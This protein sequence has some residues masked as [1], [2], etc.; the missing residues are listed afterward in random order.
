MAFERE[1]AY[2]VYN[3]L[4]QSLKRQ[5]Q[6][7]LERTLKIGLVGRMNLEGV[8]I[9]STKLDHH[10]L[11]ICRHELESIVKSLKNNGEL[12]DNQFIKIGILHTRNYLKILRKLCN[13]VSRIQN[14]HSLP[15]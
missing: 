5:C 6:T 11:E 15:L 8:E 13:D 4:V 10:R 1:N 9:L 12:S 7:Y 14:F 2:K 3:D